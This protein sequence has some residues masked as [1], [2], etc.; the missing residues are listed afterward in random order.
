MQKN[1][2][3][4]QVGLSYNPGGVESFVMNYY[5]YL[6]KKGIQFDFIC[7]YGELAYQ[8]EIIKLGGKIYFTSNVKKRPWKFHR[9]FEEILGKNHYE[10]VYV[11][12]LSAANIVPLKIS[13][14]QGVSRII[15]HSHNT[16]APGRIRNFLH[17]KNMPAVK[18][19]AT[20][21]WACGKEA[22]VWLF[23]ENSLDETVIIQ[24]AIP[25]EKFL[26]QDTVR[27][28][29][30][31]ELGI[32]H[33]TLVLGH[34][35]RM[36]EQK[37]HQFL[38]KIFRAVLSKQENAVL[39]LIGDGKLKEKLK[40]QAHL[41]DI[42]EK[43]LFLGRR[44]DVNLLLS[45]MDIFVFPSLY[46]GLSVTA[47]EAQCA[48]LPCIV[49][50]GLTEDTVIMECFWRFSLEKTPGEWAEKILEIEKN[51]HNISDN[52]KIRKRMIE[53]GFDIQTE[54]ERVYQLLCG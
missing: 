33:N 42:E 24:N 50:E 36:E 52:D 41:L 53:M 6:V 45:A 1:I 4:L 5:R 39:I 14:R 22:A 10:I 31:S 35:G 2:R 17:K 30:R 19:Y 47:V 9:E 37:N 49:S 18:K 8:S 15:A 23:G 27:Q 12:M 7:M 51:L 34:I 26:F 28:K 25:T 3:I 38:L 46:E 54:A 43:V 48:G 40:Q 32:C 11:N 16:M 29:K 13:Y 21:Y 44:N 20:D